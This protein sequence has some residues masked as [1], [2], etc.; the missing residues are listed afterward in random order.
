MK[1]IFPCFTANIAVRVYHTHIIPPYKQRVTT[2]FTVS[3]GSKENEGE[4]GNKNHVQFS[5]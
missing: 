1:T 4:G 3:G 5:T 2:L